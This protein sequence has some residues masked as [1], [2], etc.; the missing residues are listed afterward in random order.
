MSEY[1]DMWEE[2]VVAYFKVLSPN[3]FE[4]NEEK[5]EK[6][7]SGLKVPS[8]DSNRV[9]PDCYSYSLFRPWVYY[10]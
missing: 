9:L 5:E 1:G 2:A 4:E 10:I 3:L 8:W 7:E 6:P